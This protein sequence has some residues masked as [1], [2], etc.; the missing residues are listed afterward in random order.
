MKVSHEV[1]HFQKL[2]SPS[3]SKIGSKRLSERNFYQFKVIFGLYL[4]SKVVNMKLA[5]QTICG[6]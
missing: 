4:G 1:R 6:L 2:N 3:E 5:T